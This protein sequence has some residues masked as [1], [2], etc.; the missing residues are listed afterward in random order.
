LQEKETVA[1]ELQS[2][3]DTANTAIFGIDPNG[4]PKP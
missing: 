4:N 3:M 1:Q 2:L